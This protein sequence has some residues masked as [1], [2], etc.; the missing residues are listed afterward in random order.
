MQI[1][2]SLCNLDFSHKQKI[3][4]RCAVC[5]AWQTTF[6]WSSGLWINADVDEYK[7]E[8]GAE[9]HSRHCPRYVPYMVA[10]KRCLVFGGELKIWWTISFGWPLSCNSLSSLYLNLWKCQNRTRK[11]FEPVL[12]REHF[13]CSPSLQKN[14]LM[15]CENGNPI[16]RDIIKLIGKFIAS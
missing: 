16:R 3:N 4:V 14:L 15:E 1:C 12:S 7:A 13:R 2:Y 10:L 11:R 8:S 9:P 6:D 5:R